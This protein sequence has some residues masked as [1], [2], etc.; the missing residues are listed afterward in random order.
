MSNWLSLVI[1]VIIGLIFGWLI[2]MFWRRRPEVAGHT[3]D[4]IEP[5]RAVEW[6]LPTPPPV[7]EPPLAPETAPAVEPPLPPEAGAEV[8]RAAEV[9][10][11]IRPMPAASR[12]RLA[13]FMLGQLRVNKTP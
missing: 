2:D 7:A 6:T 12:I 10:A 5:T 11:R 4:A 9:A 1:G 3:E 13:G 8:T